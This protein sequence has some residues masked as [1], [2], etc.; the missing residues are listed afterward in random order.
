MYR[1]LFNFNVGS[2]EVYASDEHGAFDQVIEHLMDTIGTNE[3]YGHNLVDLVA[4]FIELEETNDPEF[5]VTC[6]QLLEER[7]R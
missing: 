6:N 5:N 7:N 2:I 1:Y 4:E 3:S